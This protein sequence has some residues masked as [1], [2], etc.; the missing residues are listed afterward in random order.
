MP[1]ITD[2]V[3]L[4]EKLMAMCKFE[5][6]DVAIATLRRRVDIDV[7]AQLIQATQL[8]AMCQHE[9]TLDMARFPECY[10]RAGKR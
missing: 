10:Q 9:M 5:L 8:I 2:N 6:A 1:D 4:I 7:R 3:K